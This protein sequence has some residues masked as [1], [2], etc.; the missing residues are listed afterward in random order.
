MKKVLTIVAAMR[1]VFISYAGAP[2]VHLPMNG[3]DEPFLVLPEGKKIEI[4]AI[5][6]FTGGGA[7]NTAASFAR[8]GFNVQT[9]FKYGNDAEGTFI[10]ND[11]K[12][13]QVD[14]S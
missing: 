2:S 14:T 3:Q 11:L 4:E 7:T 9:F 5:N 12:K 6:Y 13:E 10:I 8:L 1:D